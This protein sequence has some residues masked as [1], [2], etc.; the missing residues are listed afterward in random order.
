MVCLVTVSLRKQCLNGS[1]N[2]LDLSF[3]L[4]FNF[5]LPPIIFALTNYLSLHSFIPIQRFKN[6]NLKTEISQITNPIFHLFLY[7]KREMR[8]TKKEIRKN[9]NKRNQN[10]NPTISTSNDHN[11]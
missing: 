3:A 1:A 6:Q 11:F 2:F 8:E 10:Q 4:T 7:I 5:L 9:R